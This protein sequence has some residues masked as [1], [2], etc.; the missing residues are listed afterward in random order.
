M[1]Y[2]IRYGQLYGLTQS[3]NPEEPTMTN[4]STLQ[5]NDQL[6]LAGSTVKATLQTDANA[7]YVHTLNGEIILVQELGDTVQQV[8]LAAEGIE[9]VKEVLV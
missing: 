7:I 4:T 6:L 2:G 5:L 3:T 9:L 1:A 8:V